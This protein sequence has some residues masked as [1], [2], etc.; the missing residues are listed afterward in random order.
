MTIKTRTAHTSRAVPG[1]YE[2]GMTAR[3]ASCSA[4]VRGMIAWGTDHGDA[5]TAANVILD[6]EA[7]DRGWACRANGDFCERHR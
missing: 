7:R 3:C 1:G 4:E 5:L 2:L 6:A